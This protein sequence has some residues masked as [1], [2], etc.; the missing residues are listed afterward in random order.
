[1]DV[2]IV[3]NR[4]VIDCFANFGL[5]H[6]MTL[7]LPRD[8]TERRLL[9]DEV[10]ARPVGAIEH[11]AVVFS[12]AVLNKNHSLK[13]ELEHLALLDP[14]K[15]AELQAA[16]TFVRLQLPWGILKWE[17]HTE[18]T[19]YTL[20]RSLAD[21]VIDEPGQSFGESLTEARVVIDSFYGSLSPWL[22]GVPGRTLAALEILV[23]SAGTNFEA[24]DALELAGPSWFGHGDL[25]ASMLGN[26]QHSVAV[27]DFKINA[28]GVERFLVLTQSQT[29]ASRVGRVVQRLLEMEIYRMVALRGLPVAKFLSSELGEAERALASITHDI[30][31]RA[32]EDHLLL[33]QLAKLAAAVERANAQHNFRFSATSAYNDIFLQR[34]VELRESPVQGIQT[35]G[36]FMQRRLSPAIATVAASALRLESL[37]QRISRAGDLLRTRVDIATEQQN[38]QLLEKLTKGQSLQ[39]RLQQTVEGL[40]IAAISYY[41]V[42]LIFYLAKSFKDLGWLPV[43]PETVT[44]LAI[45]PVVLGVWFAMRRVHRLIHREQII[46]GRFDSKPPGR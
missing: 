14:T 34:M 38:H 16:T 27:T 36:E 13:Q 42:S 11:P 3:V 32:V 28:D 24:S 9:H 12:V 40:S 17:R 31:G 4:V 23:L 5:T 37:S 8:D 30:E 33:E 45:I 21:R 6:V 29:S 22:S 43:S 35:L 39:L 7:T 10:H 44:G 26:R 41:V 1:M 20:V 2:L 25:F 18:F 15:V 19:R 46:P